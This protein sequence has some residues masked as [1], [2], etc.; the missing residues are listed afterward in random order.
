MALHV[1]VALLFPQHE[2]IH[3]SIA[4][5]HVPVHVLKREPWLLN[6]HLQFLSFYFLFVKSEIFIFVYSFSLV[7]LF[8]LTA[9]YLL[10]MC[11]RLE[12]KNYYAR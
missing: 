11:S 10:E 4:T 6:F 9:T 3:T 5:A 2:H 7:L 12:V 1:Q 8:P